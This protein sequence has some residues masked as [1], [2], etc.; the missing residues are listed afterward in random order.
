MSGFRCPL[1]LAAALL[2]SLPL[3]PAAADGLDA[4]VPLNGTAAGEVPAGGGSSVTG[5][6]LPAGT[7]RGSLQL[8]VAKGS[9]L[10]PLL[11]LLYPDGT[12]RDL[13]DLAGLGAAVKSTATSVT[14]SNLPTL[15]ESGLY[16]AVV[17]GDG[18]DDG[19]PTSGAYTLRVKGKP[20]KGFKVALA[21][22]ATVGE[23][24]DYVLS[25]PEGGLLALSVKAVKGSFFAPTLQIL[26]GSGD[27]IPHDAYA[28]IGKGESISIK[29]LPLPFFGDYV[30]RI[31]APAIASTGDYTLSVKVKASKA[32]PP[33]GV[34]VADAGGLSIVEPGAA[35]TLDG[36]GTSGAATVQWAR[37]GGPATTLSSTSAS[38]PSAT[39]PPDRATVVFQLGGRNA[40]GTSAPDLAVVEVDRVPV[41]DAGPSVHL[42]APAAVGL[43]GSGSYDLDGGDALTYSWTQVAGPAVTLDDPASVA[44]SFT[45]GADGL[46]AFELTVN[47]G[48]AG[49]EPSGVVVS[50]GGSFPAADAGRNILVRP[51]D[52][53]FL[54]G[55]RSRSAS[56]ATPATFAWTADAG[57]GAAV[58]LAGASGP[59]ASFTAPKQGARLRFRLVV[60]GSTAAADEVL[61]VVSSSTPV[62][63][64]PV[65]KAGSAQVVGASTGFVLDGGQSTDDG[66]VEEHSWMQVA[67]PATGLLDEGSTA[68]GT[69]PAGDSVSSFLLAVYDG[70]KYGAPDSVV[71]VGGTRDLPTADAGADGSG[72]PGATV[73]LSSALSQPAS[74]QTL[75]SRQW[76]QVSGKDWYDVDAEDAGF[77]PASASPAVKVPSDVSSLTAQRQILMALVV[78]D[79]AGSSAADYATITFNNLPTNAQ[80]T[81]DATS[82]SPLYRPGATVAL[83]AAA[84]DN[85]GDAL[86]YAWTQVSGPP[87]G[88]TGSA[89]AHATVTAPTATA[90]LVFR[91][92]VNDLTGASNASNSDEVTIS[93]NQPPVVSVVSTP[94]S[95]PAGTVAT[96]DGTGTTDPD[97]VSLT[98]LWTE[99]PPAVGSPVTL[100]GASTAT[101]SFT[102]P[103][104]SGSVTQRRRTF[105]LTVTD[106]MGASFTVNKTVTFTPNAPPSLNAIVPGGDRVIFYSN[107]LAA[108]DKSETFTAGPTTDADGDS[109]TFSWSVKS[110][111]L[112]SST[113]LSATSGTSIAFGAPKPTLSQNSTG[114]V[115]V[116]A[117]VASDGSELSLEKT[118][119]VVVTSSFTSDIY[120]LLSAGCTTSGCHNA[121][122]AGGLSLSGGASSARGNLLNGRVSANDYQGSSFYSK[123][124][125]GSMPKNG[126]AWGA[127]LYNLVRD[128]IEPEHN[129]TSK[130]GLTTGAENN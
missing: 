106:S 103:A 87:A 37:V 83:D 19:T 91:V 55:L 85:D 34:P 69:T 108:S 68:A 4:L 88:I 11:S 107:S 86:A 60:D 46:Y 79:G 129:A 114:G 78:S 39:A 73:N 47:D 43:D 38:E 25:A 52:T 13:D 40:A 10:R 74:G 81:V 24:D 29:N 21:T 99:I 44:P 65:A 2:A 59:V 90:T 3:P 120:P 117:V 27:V 12:L 80:P 54:S 115:Y 70:R 96:L 111:P 23:K 50:V 75:S 18:D 36:S 15:A 63:G 72:S 104:Y 62:N 14:V 97:D 89:S 31:G 93:V 5:V 105:R 6:L 30:L 98:Y 48:T 82:P 33:A 77:D 92:T 28:K 66:A 42:D 49:S 100:T 110:G 109:L 123:L 124:Q 76:T 35:F 16:R 95:G 84:A 53:V 41:A 64:S 22:I 67:G 57:N 119:E 45:P 26:T 56:G 113:L 128:W 126:S 9:G 7:A 20:S 8:K 51:Q 94:S 118:V 127:H 71:V 32:A 122:G 1:L 58:T 125:D 61:V 130:P 121:A 17:R 101:A 112:T 102:Q 116:I